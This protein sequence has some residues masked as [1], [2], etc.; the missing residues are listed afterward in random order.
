MDT[1]FYKKETKGTKKHFGN[2]VEARAGLANVS[3]E[4]EKKRQE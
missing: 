4:K 3:T 1:D 2:A